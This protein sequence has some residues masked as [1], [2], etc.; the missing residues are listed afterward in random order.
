MDRIYS[1]SLWLICPLFADELVGCETS[2]YLE[3]A[4]EIVGC[5]EVC[6]VPTQLFMIVVVKAFDGC[7]LDCPVHAL[8]LAV[9]PGMARFGQAMFDIKVSTG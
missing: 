1:E 7:V 8:D 6:P 2:K 3:P 5:C 9:G 4:A